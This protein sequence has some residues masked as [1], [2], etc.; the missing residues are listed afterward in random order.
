MGQVRQPIP[1]KL[2]VSAFTGETGLWPEIREVLTARL[3]IIDYESEWLPFDQTRYYARE[4]GEGL[5]RKLVAF[6]DLTPPDTLPSVKLLANELE[7]CWT[8]DGR[9]RVN[10]DVGYVTLA[11]LV[12]ATTK[13]Y[14]HRLYIGNGIYAEVTLRYEGGEYR[15]WP[16]TY[17]DYAGPRLREVVAEIRRLLYQQLHG[18]DQT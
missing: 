14:A 11:K 15:A 1:V 7:L 4:F 5:Q 2:I 12:L 8:S 9:R 6:A 16:W 17:P 3:G 10:L 13:D 18:A